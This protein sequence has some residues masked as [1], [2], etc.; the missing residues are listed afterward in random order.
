MRNYTDWK[1]AQVRFLFVCCLF[2]SLF[3]S[4][5]P[6][7]LSPHEGFRVETSVCLQEEGRTSVSPGLLSAWGWCPLVLLVQIKP[8]AESSEGL[9]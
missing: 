3:F 9:G 8:E 5:V 4:Q 6:K 2:F 1:G 7:G